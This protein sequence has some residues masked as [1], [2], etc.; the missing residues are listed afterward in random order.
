[1]IGGDAPTWTMAG[2]KKFRVGLM[3]RVRIARCNCWAM[4]QV[5]VGEGYGVGTHVLL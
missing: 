3:G 2:T 5:T 1:M 4:K